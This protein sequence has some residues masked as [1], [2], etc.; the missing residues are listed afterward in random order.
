VRTA[1]RHDHPDLFWA[2]CGAGRGLGVVTSFEFGLHPLGP[3]VALAQIA[4]HRADAPAVLRAWRDLTLTAPDAVT[5]LAVLWVVPNDPRLP[6]VLHDQ[7]ICLVGACYAG[8]PAD[9]EAVLKPYRSLA[10]PLRD[11]SGIY[12]YAVMQSAFDWFFPDNGRYYWKSHFFGHLGDDAIDSV[13]NGEHTRVNNDSLVA[14]RHLGGAIAR[15][16]PNESA[17]AHREADYNVS[18]DGVWTHAAD[19]GRVIDWVRSTWGALRVH[20]TG[21]VYMNFAGFEDDDDVSPASWLGANAQRVERVRAAYDP[22]GLFSRA[23]ERP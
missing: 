3:D 23:A 1:S 2:A 19:D 6:D 5:S 11:M 9:A 18:V 15:V 8:D 12:P 14:V 22:D 17:Y 13:I 16:S 10:S 21:G 7:P 20:A 4:Y